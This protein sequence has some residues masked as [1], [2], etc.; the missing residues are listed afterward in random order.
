MVI[1][2]YFNL[3]KNTWEKLKKDLFWLVKLINNSA[4]EYSLQLRQ[5]YFNIYYQGNSLAKINPHS[6]GTH[7]AYIHAKFVDSSLMPKLEQYSIN[8]SSGSTSSK[9]KYLSFRIQPNRL[10]QFF[11]RSHITR[12]SNNIRSVHNGEEITI[13][14]V[15]IT[16]NPPNNKF[17]I[18]DRQ[19]A[20]HN[21]RAQIDLLALKR[22]TLDSPFHFV[23]I[24][25]KLGRNPELMKKVGV[26]INQYISRIKEHIKDYSNCYRINYR[27][28][29]ELGVF[30]QEMPSN[31]EIDENKSSVEGLVAVAGYSQTGKTYIR[32]LE[33]EIKI[34]NWKIKIHQMPAYSLF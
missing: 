4:G 32:R 24:E 26:Q 10:R 13:E 14:Q 18:I 3:D 29:Y 2:R 22:D 31:I 6:N 8:K 1:E 16:D 21:N 34:N 12:L 27:Q 11:Q 23:V 7:T 28:K 9:G 17:I 5:N 19:V 20:H 25:V 33:Q 15:I 30:S